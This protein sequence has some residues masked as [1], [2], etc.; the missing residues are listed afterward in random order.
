MITQTLLLGALLGARLGVA[1]PAADLPAHPDQIQ[2]PPLTYEP[3][4]AAAHRHVLKNGVTVFVVEDHRV[5]LVDVSITIK[6]DD[7]QEPTGLEGLHSATYDL[8]SDGGS[9]AHDAAWIEEETA[10]LGAYLESGTE[11]PYGGNLRLQTLTKDLEHGLDLAFEVLR[12][13]RFQA[14]RLREWQDK[15]LASFKERNDDPERL[16]RMEWR[17]LMYDDQ[18]FRPA[19]AA[20][21]GALTPQTLKE[22]HERW[23]HPGNLLVRVS[24]DI[25][26]K[27]ILPLLE[28]H[29]KGWKK[30]SSS[31]PNPEAG[32]AA[33]KP[34]VYLIHKP[35]NQTRVR[36]ILPGLDRDDPQWHAA[37]LMNELLGGAGMSSKLLNRIRTQEGL[38]YS[39]GSQ[40]E[41]RVFGPG[42]FWAGFQTK[43]ESTQYAMSLLVDEYRKMAAGEIDE[44]ALE[45]SKNQLI[46]AFP[47]WF[48]SASTIASVL[49]EEEL[50]GRSQGNPR[51]YQELRERVAR[52]SK[53][54]VQA[55]AR[56]MLQ[57]DQLIW[58]LVG[59]AQA[60]QAPDAGHG[61]SLEQFG[62]LTRLPL[63]DPLTQEP[64]PLD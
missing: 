18:T 3:P 23:T 37:W 24:G 7:R 6:A 15:R 61:L 20:S 22:W 58:V 52:V 30:G 11:D 62:P 48:A 34:G 59:D 60:V 8:L 64:L 55:A 19:T 27:Q 56:R 54:D 43:V 21:V 42:I 50:S 36:C 63:Y 28:K 17:R 4:Q 38:A 46:Q 13:P 14:D 33:V 1:A 29:M 41:E 26:P 9:Q 2:F 31:F 53:A 25:T 16:E 12:T 57:T 47:T 32:Y 10:F 35:I 44:E 49:A 51:F 39:V 5:P 40:L 45:N